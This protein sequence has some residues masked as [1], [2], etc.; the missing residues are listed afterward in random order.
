MKAT[1]VFDNTTTSEDLREDWGFSCVV[2]TN[3]KHMCL[4]QVTISLAM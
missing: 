3:D 4:L 2:E 1:I